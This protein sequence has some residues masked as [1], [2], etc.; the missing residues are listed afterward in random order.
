SETMIWQPE[1]TDKTL[2]R[3]PGAV[4]CVAQEDVKTPGFVGRKA[5]L[6]LRE[7]N[8]SKLRH[9]D[10]EVKYDKTGVFTPV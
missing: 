6:T 8:R 9:A 4:Q 7:E 2:S 10:T 5:L 3:K 1:F